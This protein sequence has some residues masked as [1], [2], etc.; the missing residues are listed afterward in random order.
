MDV[1]PGGAD[2]DPE[3]DSKPGVG[4]T[5]AQIREDEQ[6]LV[7]CGEPPPPTRAIPPTAPDQ[8]AELGECVGRQRDRS[9][10]GQHDEAP[11]QD[12]RSWSTAVLPGA[13]PS[14]AT[15]QRAADQR[16]HDGKGSA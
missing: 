6:G 15:P 7:A 9:R 14:P 4:V 3:P 5:V 2:R 11:G 1:A 12:G 10:V 8:R 16:T 13:S